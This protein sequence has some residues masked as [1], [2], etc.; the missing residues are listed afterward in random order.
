MLDADDTRTLALLFH[1]NS[2]PWG[3]GSEWAEEDY[4]IEFKQIRD[5]EERVI[6]PRVEEPGALLRLIGRRTSGRTFAETT[7]A[8]ADLAEILAGSYGLGRTISFPGGLESRARPVPSAGALY[9]LELYPLLA[10]VEGVDDGLYHY[11]VLTHGLER[12]R[13]D[14]DQQAIGEAMIAAPLLRNA[15]AVVFLGA[16]FD[17]TLRKYGPRG[18]R[19]ILFEAGHVAQNLCLLATERG[20]ASL[21]VG[22]FVDARVNRLLRLEPQVE[23]V[24]YC[25]ALG[26]P[27]D[28]GAGAASD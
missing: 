21:C 24:V 27:A 22:G 18:Y 9:P 2:E 5:A 1:L 26:H 7:M 13:T 20:L 12:M 17:R 6:L 28:E 11:D 4:R 25:V 16:V 23:A 10:E 3:G 15:N 19:Y 8:L 14:V